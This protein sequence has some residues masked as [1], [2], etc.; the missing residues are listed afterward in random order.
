MTTDCLYSAKPICADSKLYVNNPRDT[1]LE[2]KTQTLKEGEHLLFSLLPGSAAH[3][4][5]GYLLGEVA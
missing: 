1:F 5:E 4:V 3:L 2:Q